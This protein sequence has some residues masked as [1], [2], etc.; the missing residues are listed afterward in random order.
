MFFCGYVMR[1]SWMWCEK[2]GYCRLVVEWMMEL[3]W[4]VVAKVVVEL[5]QEVVVQQLE[6]VEVL[7]LVEVVEWLCE[8][9]IPLLIQSCVGVQ[10]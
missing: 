5:Q 8:V 10:E 4:V 3:E 6:V 2:D 9:G 7:V 1:I